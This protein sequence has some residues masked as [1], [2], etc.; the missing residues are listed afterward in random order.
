MSIATEISRLQTAKSALKTSIENK[1]VTVPSET[2]LDGYAALVDQISGG[3]GIGEVTFS[4]SLSIT[5]NTNIWQYLGIDSVYGGDSFC[6]IVL[7]NL[8]VRN[9]A[10]AYTS[11]YCVFLNENCFDQPSQSPVADAN[12]DY[13]YYLVPLVTPSNS[14]A[15]IR[16]LKND[17]LS[18][19]ITKIIKVQRA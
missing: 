10:M 7:Q 17:S 6:I 15:Y 8:Y 1:G 4:G 16:T 11:E 5:N 18:A 9:K 13:K 2:T 3:G 12:E 19:T 14:T